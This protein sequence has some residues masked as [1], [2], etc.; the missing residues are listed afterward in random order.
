MSDND[1]LRN[2][3]N[4]SGETKADREALSDM[5]ASAGDAA[6]DDSPEISDGSIL[7]FALNLEYL[8]AEFYLRASGMTLPDDMTTG[9]GTR[10]EVTGGRPVEFK[11]PVIRKF[12]AE[13]AS[14]EREHVAF[15]RNALGGA[16]VSRPAISLDQSFTAAALAAGLIKPGRPSTRTRTTS[17]SCSRHS[18]SKM[19][20]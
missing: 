7:N 8:E 3:I 17:T 10:G 12:A 9:T 2:A 15:L 1:F 19:S 20:E 13:I 11:N 4:R 16:A 14:D 18:S 5:V 6:A